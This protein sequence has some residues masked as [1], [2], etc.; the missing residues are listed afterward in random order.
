VICEEL[1]DYLFSDHA[2]IRQHGAL[3]LVDAIAQTPSLRAVLFYSIYQKFRVSKYM[4]GFIM[5][6]SNLAD[7]DEQEADELVTFIVE[8]AKLQNKGLIN[9][10]L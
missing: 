9:L 3:G 1:S 7:I 10:G 4:D 5:F 8:V 2:W 6:F